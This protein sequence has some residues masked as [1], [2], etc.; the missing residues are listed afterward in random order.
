MQFQ[1]AVE[2]VLKLKEQAGFLICTKG[3]LFG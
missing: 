3:Y 1:V 2:D